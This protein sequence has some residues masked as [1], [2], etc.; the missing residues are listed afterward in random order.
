LRQKPSHRS[1]TQLHPII[2]PNQ[3]ADHR[4][5]PQRKGKLKLQ[6]VLQGHCA[7]NPPKLRTRAA[8]SLHLYSSPFPECDFYDLL[9]GEKRRLTL[10]YDTMYGKPV[11]P[12]S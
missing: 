9:N 10:A 5:S 4:P 8:T 3:R 11:S 7:V 2:P 12:V 6:R 1:Q